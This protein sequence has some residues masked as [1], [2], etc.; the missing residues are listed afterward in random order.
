MPSIEQAYIITNAIKFSRMFSALRIEAKK[1]LLVFKVK[2]LSALS[3]RSCGC[4][5]NM[6]IMHNGKRC[7]TQLLLHAISTDGTKIKCLL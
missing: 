1:I 6:S 5:A 7:T 4:A 2:N 3:D